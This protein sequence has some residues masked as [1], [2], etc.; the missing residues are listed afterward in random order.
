MKAASATAAVTQFM[1]GVPKDQAL[2]GI[3][4]RQASPLWVRPIQLGEQYGLLLVVLA[5]DFGGKNYDFVRG[6]V[7]NLPGQNLTVEGWNA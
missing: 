1:K 7:E 2:G 3:K 5:S 4:P 6:F